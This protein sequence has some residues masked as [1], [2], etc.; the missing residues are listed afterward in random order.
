MVPVW[1]PRVVLGLRA[2]DQAEWL[3]IN[4]GSVN[5]SA[6]Q[7]PSRR[8]PRHIH[9]SE[10]G[11][12]NRL[13]ADMSNQMPD[14]IDHNVLLHLA[15]ACLCSKAPDPHRG[16]QEAAVIYRWTELMSAEAGSVRAG[17][18]PAL[19][20]ADLGL[21]QSPLPDQTAFSPPPTPPYRLS[22]PRRAATAPNQPRLVTDLPS[23]IT[24]GD[25]VYFPT[26]TAMSPRED[27][28]HRET[29]TAI[30]SSLSSIP[31]CLSPMTSQHL[32][33]MSSS[34]SSSHITTHTTP[35]S[36]PASTPN[37][38][39]HLPPSPQ[40]LPPSPPDSATTRHP[41]YSLSVLG[42]NN[43]SG[44]PI[45]EPSPNLQL[46]PGDRIVTTSLV[47]PAS[48]NI[49][50]SPAPPSAVLHQQLLH[51]Q[52]QLD[53]VSRQLAAYAAENAAIAAQASKL[54]SEVDELHAGLT[55]FQHELAAARFLLAT[56]IFVIQAV[57]CWPVAVMDFV[58]GLFDHIFL[59]S[60][61][62]SRSKAGNERPRTG[63]ESS[64]SRGRGRTSVSRSG[65]SRVRA[66]KRGNVGDLQ[67]AKWKGD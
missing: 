50:P 3:C 41:K 53:S 62:R 65:L 67:I 26:P 36:T 15:R 59:L 5:T 52:A 27:A 42:G 2:D 29:G 18:R 10:L 6:P 55:S 9:P 34:S 48:H 33:N 61:S 38:V 12:I 4:T 60:G 23:E 47:I 57:S 25:A 28:N 49:P 7:D 31:L 8:C 22:K 46:S 20:E 17:G 24:R 35:A 30:S 32:R 54:R 56:L 21:P 13:L 37:L 39:I 11:K 64:R 45:P 1:N 16:G 58:G 14:Q 40:S 44:L 19:T 43:N 63:G 51:H 66:A